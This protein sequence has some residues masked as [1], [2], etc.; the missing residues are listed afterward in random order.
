[1]PTAHPPSTTA[2]P[3]PA[4]H[5]RRD[6]AARQREGAAGVRDSVQRSALMLAA[7]VLDPDQD[8]TDEPC[9]S[10]EPASR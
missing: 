8:T 7:E 1:M 10:A 9:G 2:R 4:Q 3:R 5:W 6:M